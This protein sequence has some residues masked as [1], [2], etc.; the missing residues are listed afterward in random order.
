MK[1]Q[2]QALQ[3]VPSLCEYK[4][5]APVLEC[6][7][8]I[9]EY[10][11]IAQIGLGQG[12]IHRSDRYMRSLPV[13]GSKPGFALLGAVETAACRELRT[14]GNFVPYRATRNWP[15]RPAIFT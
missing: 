5:V 4:R 14:C 6:A 7:Q 1:S 13:V 3:V 8:H 10:A 2:S 12:S 15:L 11:V 9:V